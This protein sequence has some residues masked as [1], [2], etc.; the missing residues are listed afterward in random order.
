MAASLLPLPAAQAADPTGRA[1]TPLP[2]S[3][4]YEDAQRHAGERIRFKAGGRVTVPFKPRPGDDW[5]V[6]GGAPKILPA[7]AMSGAQMAGASADSDAPTG[8][9]TMA[10]ARILESEAG[11]E[12]SVA[13]TMTTPD[14]DGPMAWMT[15]RVASAPVGGG[16]L[17]REVFGFLPYWELTDASTRLDYSVLSTI[18]YFGVGADKDGHLIKK[19]GDGSRDVGWA[20]WTSTALTRVINDAHAKRTRVVLTVQRFAWTSSQVSATKALL[21]STGA[22]KTLAEEIAKAV[23][24]RG[25]DGVNLDFEPIPSGYGDEYVTF[26]RLV[27]RA[28][29]ARAGGY[30]LTFDSTGSIGAYDIADLTGPGAADAVFIMGYDYRTSGAA[31]AGSIAPLSGPR[32]DLTDTIDAYLARIGPG[33]IILGVPYYGRAWST[34]SDAPNARTRPGSSTTGYSTSVLYATAVETAAK[35]GR[36]WDGTESTAWSA[37]KW[38]ACSDCPAT[39]RELYYD[40]T[41]SLGLKYDLINER[42]LRGVGLWALGY[43]G[44]RPELYALL[45]AKFRE[46]SSAPTAGIVLLPA[47]TRDATLQVRWTGRDDSAVDRYDVQVSVDGRAWSTWLDDTSRTSA[48]YRGA[49]GHGYAFRVRAR[50]KKGHWSAW[51]VTETWRVSAGPLKVGAFLRVTADSL[52]LRASPDASARKVGTVAAGARLRIVGGPRTRDGYTWHKVVGP[53]KEWGPVAT[54]TRSGVWVATASGARARVKVVPAPNTTT[55][56]VLIGELAIGAVDAVKAAKA[57]ST[58]LPSRLTAAFS[59]SSDKVRDGLRISY[60]LDATVDALSLRVLRASDGRVVGTRSLPGRARG[61]HVF[62]W[63]G[64]LGGKR[65]ADGTYL[66]QLVARLGSSSGSSPTAAM[67]DPTFDVAAWTATI[68]TSAPTVSDI[69]AGAGAV[70]PD[71]DDRH[72][73]II[74]AATAGPG[75]ATWSLRIRDRD[76]RVRRSFEGTRRS[77]VATWD[78]RDERGARVSDG[79]YKAELRVDDALGNTATTSRSIS[80]DTLDPSGTVAPVVAGLVNGATSRAFSPDGDRWQDAVLLRVQAA[81]PVSASISVRNA[82]GT[83]LWSD[84]A[85]LGQAPGVVW[86]GRD[87]SGRTLKDGN[88]R[89]VAKVTDAA[90]NR[91]TLTGKVRID[92]TAGHLRSAPSLFFPQD[93]DTLAR[94]T[95][96]TFKLR[97]RATTTLRVVAADGRIVRTAWND[98]ARPAGTSTW[99][100]DGRDG[101]GGLVP[102]GRYQLELVATAGG[103]TQVVRRGLI[104]DAFAITPSS[105]APAAGSR[106]T[107]II[108]TA[109]SLKGSPTVTIG[110]PGVP[111]RTVTARRQDDGRYRAD[112]TLALG[113]KGTAVV[114]VKGT[115]VTGK[116]NTATLKLSVH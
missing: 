25:A 93:G 104:V 58:G 32:Y 59:P 6:D 41:Q 67:T 26:V 11:T 39:W 14:L 97:D 116:P 103:V 90:G 112:L 65:V 31:N 9:P 8:A 7:G 73:T 22:R 91:S 48:T 78:G 17:R 30:Q 102:R 75:A 1:G 27:R 68:D 56:D 43:D 16:G 44:S 54:S 47:T 10:P 60:R 23:A 76:G 53:L 34:I 70:S 46:D 96:A 107:L 83:I 72:D 35:H 94:A 86:K 71:G 3:A 55:L 28:L 66:V 2:T 82:A 36:R 89:I 24:D 15:E 69:G 99:T 49:D 85:R 79:T 52:V 108:A 115:D 33:K 51:N 88:Y 62:D 21:G 13:P 42:G 29:D 81:E 106:L 87:R 110:Q 20:G 105:S 95:R 61:R 74:L 111:G 37:Y 5:T 63:D 57:T 80:V 101:K 92:R 114:T 109:E 77:I 98:R 100:W 50:D 113:V 18:A 45:K 19:R 4:H 84:D 12:S 64:A 40:D 38:K